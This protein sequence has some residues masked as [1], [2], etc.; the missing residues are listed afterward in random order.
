M[1]AAPWLFLRISLHR[2]DRA[3]LKRVRRQTARAGK[4]CMRSR[5][6]LRSQWRRLPPL[7]L[8][9]RPRSD[10]N[11]DRPDRSLRPAEQNRE[12]LITQTRTPMKIPSMLVVV[13]GLVIVSPRILAQETAGI[14][15][16]LGVEGDSIIV[17][18]VL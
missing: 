14:G 10:R 16:V 3:F 1:R 13:L 2:I 17:R 9:D 5:R 7:L 6:S 12:A 15:V 11:R 4:G 8:R 18:A